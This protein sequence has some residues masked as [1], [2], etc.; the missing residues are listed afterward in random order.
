M[1]KPS[2]LTL[3]N[4][5]P[6]PDSLVAD[7]QHNGDR[8]YQDGQHRWREDAAGKLLYYIR[9]SANGDRREAIYERRDRRG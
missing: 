4:V 2:R 5:P 1:R 3:D 9:Y 8:M 6:I 7:E